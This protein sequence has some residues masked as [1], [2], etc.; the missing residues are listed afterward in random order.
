[1][2]KRLVSIL[3]T[4][5]MTMSMCLGLGHTA[6]AATPKDYSAKI[7]QI[8]KKIS[9]YED[10]IEWY[11]AHA[12]S[13]AGL[14]ATGAAKV[15]QSNP[16]IIEVQGPP[17]ST[18]KKGYIR[19]VNPMYDEKHYLDMFVGV[20]Y[21]SYVKPLGTVTYY[22]NNK[23]VPDYKSVDINDYSSEIA[24]LKQKISDLCDELIVYQARQY[25]YNKIMNSEYYFRPNDGSDRITDLNLDKGQEY[26][27][28]M[29][30]R[31]DVDSTYGFTRA[32]E[33][34]SWKSSNKKVATINSMGTQIVAK[35]Y[36]DAVITATGKTSKKVVKLNVHVIKPTKNITLNKSKVTISCGRTYKLKAT[37]DEGAGD[38][39][40]YLSNDESVAWVEEK[41]GKIH[42]V[43]PGTAYIAA[44]TTHGVTAYCKVNVTNKN[45]PNAD[46][47]YKAILAAKKYQEDRIDSDNIYWYFIQKQNKKSITV[48]SYKFIECIDSA[49]S[50][51]K[52]SKYPPKATFAAS[53]IYNIKQ[54]AISMKTINGESFEGDY[55]KASSVTIRDKSF[56]ENGYK[57]LI[58]D[59]IN[60]VYT[61]KGTSIG[62]RY[63]WKSSNTSVA[64]VDSNGVVKCIGEGSVDISF[65]MEGG[66]SD[67]VTVTVYKEMPSDESVDDDYYDDYWDYSYEESSIEATC[68]EEIW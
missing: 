18:V 37:L 39:V 40:Y 5:V 21:S 49:I 9:E 30:V 27:G 63:E 61:I 51:I 58:G 8:E 68:E 34:F 48:A 28:F 1:M 33:T 20:Y 16:F 17:L 6:I 31:V 12:D 7:S 67:T 59:T 54:N 15:V 11:R 32:S 52:K 47:D 35:G 14:E 23:P 25:E 41:T 38:T 50:L 53:Y 46:N 64:T 26:T 56:A 45:A 57:A 60:F 36:G 19:I 3:L 4:L 10:K 62:E 13:A 24:D 65:I 66:A 29:I 22:Y 42:S 2:K 55:K 43:N 44:F